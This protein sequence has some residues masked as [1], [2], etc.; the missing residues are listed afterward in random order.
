MQQYSVF[1]DPPFPYLEYLNHYNPHDPNEA[2]DIDE[3]EQ[4]I[5]TGDGT[6][7]QRNKDTKKFERNEIMKDMHEHA[8]IYSKLVLKHEGRLNT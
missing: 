1:D 2:S 7:W 5:Y 4:Y 8:K 6:F 3:T